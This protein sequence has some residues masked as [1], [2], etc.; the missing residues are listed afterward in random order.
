MRGAY[1]L[2]E[3][4][5]PPDAVLIGTGS[6]VEICLKAEALLRKKG[7]NA[8]VVSM[9]CWELF[10]EQDEEYRDSVLPPHIKNRVSVEAGAT[11]GWERW[12]GDKGVVV[13]LDRFGASAPCERLYEEF[14]LTPERIAEIVKENAKRVE[15]SSG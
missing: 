5:S 10:E 8:R 9:P 1:I 12:V 4:D 7:V 13:G 11:L 3:P 14:G 2:K 6:E 15:S